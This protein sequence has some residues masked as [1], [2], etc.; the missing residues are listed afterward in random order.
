MAHGEDSTRTSKVV[1]FFKQGHFSGQIRSFTMST[2]N[3]GELSDYVASAIGASVHYET[4]EW[5][6]LKIGLNGLFV[7][8]AFSND[9]LELDTLVGKSSKYELQ[10]FDIEHPGNYTD[11]DRLEELYIDYNHNHWN[12]TIGKMEIE[13]PIINKHDGRMKPKV[14]LGA[15]LQY[16]SDHL[17]LFGGWFSKASP[18]SITHWYGIGDVIGLYNNGC[19]PDG[20]PA[21]YHHYISSKGLGI[22]GT[23]LK[24]K[25]RVHLKLWNY[26][27]DNIS[28]TVLVN[29][30]YEDSSFYVGMMYVNQTGINNG[31]SDIL[32]RTYFNPTLKTHILSGRFGYTYTHHTIQLSASHVF[33]GGSFVFPRE[34]GMDPL[35][36][37]ISRSQM[38]GFGNSSAFTLGYEYQKKNWNLGAYWNATKVDKDLSYNKYDIPSYHQFNLDFKYAFPNTLQGLEMRFLYVYRKAMT[39]DISYSQA[40]N[41]VDFNQFN[42]IF[43]FNF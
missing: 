12:A 17:N 35:Y 29:P 1:D 31:G 20:S 25:S 33:E 32:E 9:L 8:K 28:N 21:E 3:D 23:E 4:K 41:K 5:K 10:L 40:F 38:E 42:L 26:Y 37:F 2:I 34:I 13:T 39:D 30:Y 36:T 16:S 7:Y 24:V 11:L 19:L 22:L 6:R 18:R 43:N 14:F 15:K 27:L